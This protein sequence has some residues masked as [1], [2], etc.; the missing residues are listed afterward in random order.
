MGR[1]QEMRRE[2]VCGHKAFDLCKGME[3]TATW[4]N[5]EAVHA[6][7]VQV[8]VCEQQEEVCVSQMFSSH[9]TCVISAGKS[10][11]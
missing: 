11:R 1:I 8:S 3:T 5:E 10:K 6:D 9:Q 2:Q 4:K 7:C